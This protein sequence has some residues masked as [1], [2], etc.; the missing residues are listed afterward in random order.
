MHDS[1][2]VL[3]CVAPERFELKPSGLRVILEGDEI[4]KT[5]ADD[6]RPD[7]HIAMDV[8]A[9]WAVDLAMERIATLA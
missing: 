6:S 3:A 9:K 2:A 5:V 8:D 1:T 4:G 7:V